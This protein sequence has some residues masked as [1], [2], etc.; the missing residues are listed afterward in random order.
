MTGTTEAMTGTTEA[1]AETTDGA[2]GGAGGEA[3]V[4]LAGGEVFVTGS[5]TVEPISIRVGE[6]AGELSGGGLA[7]HRRRPRHG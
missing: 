4:E 1:M 2:G 6:L 5:S 3:P 7:G